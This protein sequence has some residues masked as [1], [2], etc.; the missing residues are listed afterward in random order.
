MGC[1]AAGGWP[2]R[3]PPARRSGNGTAL[4]GKYTEAH[5]SHR[6]PRHARH[7]GGPHRRIRRIEDPGTAVVRP[8]GGRSRCRHACAVQRPAGG[9]ALRARTRAAAAESRNTGSR[10]RPFWATI[11]R[12]ASFRQP[13]SEV[14]GSMLKAVSRNRRGLT[15]RH[16]RRRRNAGR[17]SAMA[18]DSD[19][20]RSRAL[21]H[22]GRERRRSSHGTLPTPASGSTGPPAVRISGPIREAIRPEGEPRAPRLCRSSGRR[23][24]SETLPSPPNG[25]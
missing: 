9:R 16:R 19:L 11:G 5:R 8:F 13:S 4:R 3:V 24:P 7:R 14:P 15:R 25:G 23:P 22:R 21:R 17:R 2:P 18:F 20:A 12:G 10:W 6:F 1:E